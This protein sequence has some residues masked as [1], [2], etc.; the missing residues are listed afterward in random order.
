M[1]CWSHRTSYV[2]RISRLLYEIPGVHWHGYL[3]KIIQ[4][5]DLAIDD[6]MIDLALTPVWSKSC[7]G[8]RWTSQSEIAAFVIGFRTMSFVDC[9]IDGLSLIPRHTHLFLLYFT[10]HIILTSSSEVPIPSTACF[11]NYIDSVPA[12]LF[13][14][15]C[16]FGMEWAMLYER[17]VC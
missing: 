11:W 9:M 15:R 10:H 16:A 1:L 12:L 3:S 17:R 14:T 4:L 8:H 7:V 2:K 5:Y 13:P 6:C